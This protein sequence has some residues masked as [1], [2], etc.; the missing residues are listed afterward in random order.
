[1]WRISGRIEVRQTQMEVDQNF[2]ISQSV[3]SKAW[4]RFLRTISI[5]RQPVQGDQEQ[6]LHSMIAFSHCL[7]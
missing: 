5:G 2:N 4:N 7:L 3:V 1:M 6:Q